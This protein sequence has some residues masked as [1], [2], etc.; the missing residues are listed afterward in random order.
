MKPRKAT[1]PMQ[2]ILRRY[3]NGSL[4]ILCGFAVLGL[5]LSLVR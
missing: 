4:F 2:D 3:R 1:A 5:V